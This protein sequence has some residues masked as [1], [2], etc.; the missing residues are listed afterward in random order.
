MVLV[1]AGLALLGIAWILLRSIGD[2]ARV[3]RILAATPV[4][5]VA[6]ALEI[7]RA[8]QARYVAVA[9]RIDAE[10][11]FEDEHHR[12]LV[13]P[14]DPARVPDGQGLDARSRTT[15]RSIPFEIVDGL[16]RIAVDADALDVGLVVVTRE[17]EGTAA[18]V[19]D[20]VPADLPPDTPVRLRIEQLSSVDHAV[21]CGMPVLDDGGVADPPPRPAATADRVHARWP[22]GDAAAG[23][24]SSRDH[25]G[26]R[27]PDGRGRR[28]GRRGPDLVGRRCGGLTCVAC[29]GWPPSAGAAVLTVLAL[30]LAVLGATPVPTAVAAGD[31]RSSGQGPGL[32]GDPLTA[33]LVVAAIA[34]LSIGAT[35]LYVRMTAPGA[36]RHRS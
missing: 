8:G 32:V 35:L 4:V 13:L 6:R 11:E 25:A 30:P 27:R 29:A 22:G 26:G 31:P 16:D 3:G 33:I 28:R 17:S 2:N 19:P 7:A 5:P 18:D 21:A 10:D 12:P 36:D 1:L 9:G 34:V 24:R 14:P 23:G 20:L 15:A